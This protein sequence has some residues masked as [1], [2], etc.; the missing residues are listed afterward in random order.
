MASARSTKDLINMIKANKPYE[1]KENYANEE[2]DK[3]PSFE[4][5]AKVT[6][7]DNLKAKSSMRASTGHLRH[8]SGYDKKTD[9][10]ELPN[11][12]HASKVSASQLDLEQKLQKLKNLSQ[13]DKEMIDIQRK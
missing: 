5:E 1:T 12:K 13:N 2:Y 4:N 6:Y 3:F 8:L 9:S 10:V 11:I 7:A